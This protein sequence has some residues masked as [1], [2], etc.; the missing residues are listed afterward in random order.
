MTK[1]LVGYDASEASHRALDVAVDRAKALGEEVVLVH[2]LDW[3]PYSFL[4]TQELEE[5]HMR[6]Q[7]ELER[8]NTA[9]LAPVLAKLEAEGVKASGQIKYGKIA[10]QICKL[11]SAQDASQIFIGRNGHSDFSARVFGSV[12]GTLAQIAPVPVTIVP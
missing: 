9:L 8:A 3:S 11:A 5:R 2:I 7:E 4:S 6:R 1:V 12:A 10:E